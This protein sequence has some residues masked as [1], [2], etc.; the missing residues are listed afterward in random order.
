M[1]VYRIG[2]REGGSKEW[3]WCWNRFSLCILVNPSKVSI[4]SSL[5]NAPKVG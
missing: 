5:Q 4:I 2:V 3:D 1:Q